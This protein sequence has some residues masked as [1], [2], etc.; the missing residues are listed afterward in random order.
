MIA[1]RRVHHPGFFQYL[2]PAGFTRLY[3]VN[4]RPFYFVVKVFFAIV[5]LFM[6]LA[7]VNKLWELHAIRAYRQ[8]VA[9][10]RQDTL[11]LAVCSSRASVDRKA[12]PRRQ[13]QCKRWKIKRSLSQ[14]CAGTN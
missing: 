6:Y 8:H 7:N 10:L 12:C 1:R 14:L 5:Q 2:A 3:I 13:P 4:L 11:P 9:A